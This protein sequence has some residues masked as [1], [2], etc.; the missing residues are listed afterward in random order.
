MINIKRVLDFLT[1]INLN[2]NREW[3][4]LHKDTYS[5]INSEIK[6]LTAQLIIE[7]SHF[8]NMFNLKVEDCLYRIYR[9][10]RFSPDKS[11]YKTYI[12]IYVCKG[13]KKS[14]LPGYYLHFQPGQCMVSGG[15]YLPTKE[16][17]NEIRTV[18]YND[19]QPYLDIV[20]KDSFKNN[21]IMS[22]E[23]KLKTAPKGFD[24]NFEYIDILRNVNF[25]PMH[26]YTDAQVLEPD[27][28]KSAI[29][30]LANLKEYNNYLLN[31]ID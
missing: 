29:D 23:G 5:E 10:V 15:V 27:F 3:F 28:I 9:D 21:F 7:I 2:N 13:G 4:T 22:V 25:V 26:F 20:N 11:P 18:I 31:I 1:Q 30:M 12:G 14:S 8:D 19:P 16:Q 17:L 6:E 24:K